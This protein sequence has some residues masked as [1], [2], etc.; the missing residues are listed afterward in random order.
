VGSPLKTEA[1]YRK[2]P[3]EAS[4][5]AVQVR[6][7]LSP[8]NVAFKTIILLPELLISIHTY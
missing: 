8:T 5:F 1:P 7:A 3:P 6:P 4:G 2:G